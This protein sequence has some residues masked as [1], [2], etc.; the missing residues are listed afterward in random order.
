[1]QK[2]S[3]G[4]SLK[5]YDF[6]FFGDDSKWQVLEI[7]EWGLALAAYPRK[8]MPSMYDTSVYSWDELDSKNIRRI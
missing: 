8:T 4:R 1:M 6:I 7:Y 2:E 3:V 5:M